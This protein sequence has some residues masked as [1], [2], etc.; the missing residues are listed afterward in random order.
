MTQAQKVD[1]SNAVVV[2]EVQRPVSVVEIQRLVKTE[3]QNQMLDVHIQNELLEVN[4]TIQ[5]PILNVNPITELYLYAAI[6]VGDMTLDGS[7][8][9]IEGDD[10]RKALFL[11]APETNTEHV[12]IQGFLELRPGGHL[13]LKTR[14]AILVKGKVGEHLRIGEAR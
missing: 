11:Q 5:N 6:G 3:I 2:H 12:L 8:Q 14:Q 7:Q 4:A 10:E 1:V 13:A 9:T